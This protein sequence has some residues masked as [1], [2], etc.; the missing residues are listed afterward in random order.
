M[1]QPR[2]ELTPEE[3]VRM[4]RTKEEA[5]WAE[6][7]DRI[8]QLEA[9]WNFIS[10]RAISDEGRGPRCEHVQHGQRCTRPRVAGAT[11]LAPLPLR[12]R[13][14]LATEFADE[15][16]LLLRDDPEQIVSRFAVGCLGLLVD[17]RL[18]GGPR[19]EEAQGALRKIC[20]ALLAW[21]PSGQGK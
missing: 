5:Y 18:R 6:R 7:R 14:H 1:G 10:S 19:A 9:R 15:L 8:Q 17:E 11:Q 3:Q 12:C 2:P 21:P 4:D 16:A 20:E 13:F